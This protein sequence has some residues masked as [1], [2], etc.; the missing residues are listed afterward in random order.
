MG[1]DRGRLIVWFLSVRAPCTNHGRCLGGTYSYQ[2]KHRALILE[3]DARLGGKAGI[4]N[5][6][7]PEKSLD[8][9]HL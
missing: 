6:T 2:G 1:M 8:K 5:L 7:Q 4:T 3:E 9:S